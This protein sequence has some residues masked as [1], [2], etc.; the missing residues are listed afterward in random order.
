M[1]RAPRIGLVLGGGGV[2]GNAY[3]L[4][5]IKAI[6]RVSGWNSGTAEITIGT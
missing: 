2:I 1:A 6:R 5:V 4:G 3:L